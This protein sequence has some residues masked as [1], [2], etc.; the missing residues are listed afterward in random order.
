[1]IEYELFIKTINKYKFSLKLLHKK[2]IINYLFAIFIM[3]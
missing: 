3:T 2:L 1:M